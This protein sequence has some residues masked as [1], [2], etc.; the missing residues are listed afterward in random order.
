MPVVTHFMAMATDQAIAD[1]G[2]NTGW[3]LSNLPV[4]SFES[5]MQLNEE[6]IWDDNCLQAGIDRV[7]YSP[8]LK[9]VVVNEG[10]T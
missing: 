1:L 4:A 5:Q 6:A 9:I 8:W 2:D 10:V 3:F 7:Y